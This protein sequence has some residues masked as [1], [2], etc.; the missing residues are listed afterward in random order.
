LMLVIDAYAD[1]KSRR[2]V[3]KWASS[4][5]E[6]PASAAH[7]P[8]AQVTA[9]RRQLQ[10]IA[11]S[12]SASTAAAAAVTRRRVAALPPLAIVSPITTTAS[13]PAEQDDVAVELAAHDPVSA[14]DSR[15]EFGFRADA[16]FSCRGPCGRNLPRDAFWRDARR[17]H[18]VAYQCKECKSA[19]NKDYRQRKRQEINEM[20]RA[21]NAL[22]D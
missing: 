21:L 12:A 15:D 14:D 9:I 20:R 7:M 4:E 18:N 5:Q 16:L 11:R 3:A 13:P 2:A 8:L 22:A 1:S 17:P 6:V 10:T 19:Q